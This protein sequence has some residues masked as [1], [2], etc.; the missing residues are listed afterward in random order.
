MQADRVLDH[1]RLA[2]DVVHDRIEIAD[3][4]QA[5]AAQR[6]RVGHPA[7]AVLADVEGVLAVMRGGRIAVGHDHL[8]ERGAV[9]DPAQAAVVVVGDLVQDQALAAGETH[10]ELPLLPAHE[11]PLDGE[12]RPLGLDDLQRLEVGAPGLLE[13]RGVVVLGE[14]HRRAAVVVDAHHLEAVEVDD[15]VQP[16]DR[17]GIA[18]VVLVA[19]HPDEDVRDAQVLLV[20]AAIAAGG[21]GVDLRTSDI[22]DAA[23]PER[24]GKA[25]VGLD[26][27]LHGRELFGHDRGPRPLD[28]APGPDF[29]CIEVDHRLEHRIGRD[30]EQRDKGLTRD[31]IARP[32]GAH[33]RL[34]GLLQLDGLEADRG[35]EPFLGSY[36]PRRARDLL[37]RERVER[38]A[39]RCVVPEILVCAPVDRHGLASS[40]Y[41]CVKIQTV[42]P[43][44]GKM[45][46]PTLGRLGQ[47]RRSCPTTLRRQ[48]S[49]G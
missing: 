44:D 7:D 26:A 34:G 2:R 16:L 29:G 47:W 41:P 46:S 25:R 49:P 6:Q 15:D 30:V 28:L 24:L 5:V 31:R 1:Q 43:V 19:L 35:A 36:D 20:G 21:P 9:E 11:V 3:H 27:L 10:S 40:P 18:V 48:S 8:G 32:P 45:F 22:C 4:A 17:V 12:A 42:R 13:A 39:H 37:G 14:R 23:P 33:R 38:V